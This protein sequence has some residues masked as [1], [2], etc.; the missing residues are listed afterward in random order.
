MSNG[1]I[2]SITPLIPPSVNVV[3]KPSANSIGVSR[4][5]TPRHSVASQEKILMPVGTAMI[6]VV[7][8]IGMRIQAAIPEVNMWCAQT[9]K[10][11]PT[12]ASSENAIMR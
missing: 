9:V 1:I 5:S 3:R 2:A 6:A 4:C 8:A 11:S 10:P 12:I 7:I